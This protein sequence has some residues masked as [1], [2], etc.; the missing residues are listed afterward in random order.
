VRREAGK[1]F[2]DGVEDLDIKIQLLFWGEK[3][4][5]EVLR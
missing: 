3:T 1:A 4:V 2:P 5:K